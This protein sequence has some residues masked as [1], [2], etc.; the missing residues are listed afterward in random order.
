MLSA[1]YVCD[2]CY[3]D[4]FGKFEPLRRPRKLTQEERHKLALETKAKNLEEYEA[5]I[6]SRDPKK[7]NLIRNDFVANRKMPVRREYEQSMQGWN[8]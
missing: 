7:Y 2:V 5:M 6:K 3:P 4:R 1:D 8:K